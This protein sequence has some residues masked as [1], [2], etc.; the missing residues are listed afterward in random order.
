MKHILTGFIITV[1]LAG[2]AFATETIN[3]W[4]D[5]KFGMSIEDVRS[6]DPRLRSE[7]SNGPMDDSI[8][9]F[10]DADALEIAGRTYRLSASFRPQDRKLQNITLSWESAPDLY[11]DEKRCDEIY[12]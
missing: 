6:A 11:I 2:S 7:E 3:G 12:Q 5:L 9:I 4:G 10:S 1:C 8:V